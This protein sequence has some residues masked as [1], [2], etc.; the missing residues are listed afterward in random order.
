M[1]EAPMISD[2]RCNLIL[3]FARTLFVNGQATDQTVAATERLSRAL[4]L[5][6]NVMVRW[7]AL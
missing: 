5:R 2:E 1:G 4:D 6:A 7:G 3:T